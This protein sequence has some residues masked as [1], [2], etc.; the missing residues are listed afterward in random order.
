M[1]GAGIRHAV[2]AASGPDNPRNDT[3]SVA[4]LA[5]GTLLAVWHKY[6]DGPKGGSDFGLC[7]IYAKRSRDGG[8][9]WTDERM[10][11]D[12]AAGDNNVQAPALCVLPGGELLLVCLRGHAEDSS[13]M[14]LYRS[15][16]QGESFAEEPPIWSRSSGQWLQGGASGLYLLAD[17]SLLLP[18]HGGSGTQGGQHNT[19][20]CFRSVDGGRSWR[21]ADGRVRLPMRGAMEASVAEL[22]GGRL[23]MSIR[24]QLG[25]VFVSFSDDRGESWSLPQTTGLKSP[26]SCTCIR[27]LPGGRELVLFWNDSLYDPSIHHYGRRTPLSAAVSSDGGE[28][29]RRAGVVEDGP[30]ELTN[31]GCTF[32]RSGTAIV[33]YMKVE[34]PGIVQG[35]PELPF[36]RTGIDLVCAVIAPGWFRA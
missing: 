19:I 24:S 27:A 26:E 34:D 32:T 35:R 36:R 18:F 3:A 13:T 9:T 7:R 1:R 17:G 5:D 22:D 15:R 21:L 16:D 11:V 30:F 25:A 31:L 20:G 10:L 2:I 14:C 33:T 28:S 23:V 12:A 6:E 4:E 29:W 8:L